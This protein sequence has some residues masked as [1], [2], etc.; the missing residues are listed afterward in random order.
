MIRKKL[1]MSVVVLGSISGCSERTEWVDV[2]NVDGVVA[3]YLNSPNKHETFGNLVGGSI[4]L[5]FDSP[6]L[7][8]LEDGE[9][10]SYTFTQA[11]LLI[12]CAMKTYSLPDVSYYT[13]NGGVMRNVNWRSESPSDLSWRRLQGG[14]IIGDL[15]KSIGKKCLSDN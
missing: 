3:S 11:T 1:V 7:L 9:F 2:K 12:N 15:V 8:M 6:Q 5:K 14:E 4:Q 13:L 10:I